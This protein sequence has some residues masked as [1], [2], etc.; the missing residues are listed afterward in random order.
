VGRIRA[1]VETGKYR[2]AV[3][4]SITVTTNDP[5]RPTVQLVVR[6]D[7]V[8]SVELLPGSVLTVGNLQGSPATARMVVRKEESEEGALR[9]ENVRASAPWLVAR[10][11]LWEAGSLAEAIRGVPSPE[12]G[13]WIL[14]AE[15]A[16]DPPHGSRTLTVSFDTG[17][18]REPQVRVPVQVLW[19]PAIRFSAP[20]VV[21]DLAASSSPP[22]VV[23]F[24]PDVD[25]ASAT[26]SA[27]PEG[28]EARME[29]ANSRSMHV[30]LRWAGE[31]DPPAGGRVVVTAGEDTAAS[32]VRFAGTAA[33]LP[34]GR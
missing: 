31:G 10:A 25:V 15:I 28:L 3:S 8:G 21:F 20:V 2:G 12:E 17:L 32:E 33:P 11:Y 34:S 7:I 18:S 24:R 22:L 16:A 26:I 6:A 19:R 29:P 4:K 13:D 27:E 14:E 5:Q 9:I 23:S 1:T 30:R